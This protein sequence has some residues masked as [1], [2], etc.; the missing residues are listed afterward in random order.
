M[1]PYSTPSCNFIIKAESTWTQG[2]PPKVYQRKYLIDY[3]KP[4]QDLE[5]LHGSTVRKYL[6]RLVLQLQL[7]LPWLKKQK[8][9]QVLIGDNL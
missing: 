7:V 8:A 9:K 4:D 2:G 1:L 3:A 6:R 5:Q